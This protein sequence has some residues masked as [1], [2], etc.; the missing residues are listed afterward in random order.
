MN[1][2]WRGPPMLVRYLRM[3]GMDRPPRR[4]WSTRNS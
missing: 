2:R 1:Q 3:N 4:E